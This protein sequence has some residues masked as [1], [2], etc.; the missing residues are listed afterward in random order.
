MLGRSNRNARRGCGRQPI[1][2]PGRG[3]SL[4]RPKKLHADK[5]Y[6]FDR[7]RKAI[8]K[9]ISTPCIA[10]RGVDSSERLGWHRRVVERTLPWLNQ[11]RWLRVR[12]ERRANIHQAFL[13][14]GYVLIR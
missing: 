4:K 3:H 9:R 5:G 11:F 1:R 12:Y 7:C 2:G 8:G 10:R 14:L 13:I 6:D